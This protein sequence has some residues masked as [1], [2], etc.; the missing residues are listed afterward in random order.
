[1]PLRL[2]YWADLRLGAQK[3]TYARPPERPTDGSRKMNERPTHGSMKKNPK[4]AL[5]GVPNPVSVPKLLLLLI[6]FRILFSIGRPTAKKIPW[7]IHQK[8]CRSIILHFWTILDKNWRN[9][10][11]PAFRWYQK[12]AWDSWVFQSR[13]NIVQWRI[14]DIQNKHKIER[15]PKMDRRI[16]E[17]PKIRRPIERRHQIACKIRTEQSCQNARLQ[18]HQ[19]T[20]KFPKWRVPHG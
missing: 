19:H 16:H 2:W 12:S 4:L 1:M 9:C 13:T 5:R 7:A 3:S 18:N 10:S 8:L 11:M 14:A 20:W 15:V 17:I 6:D